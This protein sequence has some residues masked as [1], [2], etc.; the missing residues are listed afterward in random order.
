MPNGEKITKISN[1]VRTPPPH[2][3]KS[4]KWYTPLCWVGYIFPETDPDPHQNK[5]DPKH[6]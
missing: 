5:V 6:W 4:V 3:T 1:E 2:P